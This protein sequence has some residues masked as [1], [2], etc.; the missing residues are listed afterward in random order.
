MSCAAFDMID[1]FNFV[2]NVYIDDVE[3][4]EVINKLD[5]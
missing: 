4:L 2:D 3:N 5:E 1:C